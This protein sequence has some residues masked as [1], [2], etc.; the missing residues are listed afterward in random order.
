MM[1][2]ARY[3]YQL[4]F[5]LT[6]ALLLPLFTLVPKWA[7][8]GRGENWTDEWLLQSAPFAA[9][10]TFGWFAT[11]LMVWW[12]HR[13]VRDEAEETPDG[14]PIRV[15]YD[16]LNDRP[17]R[18]ADAALLGF[19]L[20]GVVFLVAATGVGVAR[21]THR[22]HVALLRFPAFLGL[23]S[24]AS[25]MYLQYAISYMRD[26]ARCKRWRRAGDYETAEGPVSQYQFF[27]D[28]GRG[29]V[30]HRA[31][32]RV[33]GES[34]SVESFGSQGGFRLGML[35]GIVDFNFPEFLVSGVRLRVLHHEG[36]ILRIEVTGFELELS[37]TEA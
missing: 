21:G 20:F 7:A 13:P 29:F 10:I 24:V 18:P 3:V 27:K 12:W 37:S 14:S 23:W 33:G 4:A 16:V 30:S 26:Q 11:Q 15:A 5:I 32:F 34:F 2:I 9:I 25:L 1:G 28:H 17:L 19:Y 22:W 36:R 31:T 35:P 8:F 6:L